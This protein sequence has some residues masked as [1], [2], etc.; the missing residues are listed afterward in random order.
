VARAITHGIGTHKPH[1]VTARVLGNAIGLALEE[2]PLITA[3]SQ[4]TF[5]AG[6]VLSLR[7]GVA[8]EQEGA[9]ASAM[10][11]VDERGCDVQWPAPLPEH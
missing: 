4:E 11:A 7:V 8:D 6:D 3:E 5:E 10:V 1:P 2:H 9:I